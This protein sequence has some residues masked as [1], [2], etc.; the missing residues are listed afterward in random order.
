MRRRMMARLEEVPTWEELRRLMKETFVPRSYFLK[1]RGEL[2]DL[3]QWARSH[4][5]QVEALREITL[6]EVLEF[7]ETF[8]RQSKEVT[9]SKTRLASSQAG[10]GASTNKWSTPIKRVEGTSTMQGRTPYKASASPQTTLA[11]ITME[12]M[13]IG[14][15]GSVYSEDEEGKEKKE[16]DTSCNYEFSSEEEE[17]E[18]MKTLVVLRMLNVL[19]NLEEHREQQ[20]NIFHMKCKMGAKTCLVIIDGGS[21]ANEVSD[22]LVE[23]LGLKVVKHSHPYKLQWLGDAGELRVESQ[24]KMSLNLGEW[25]D[26]VLCDIISMTAYHA[27]LGRP[28]EYDRKVYKNGHIN[29]YFHMLNGMKLTLRPLTPKEV[30]EASQHLQRERERD[31]EKRLLSETR[32]SD[33]GW[34]LNSRSTLL[35][36]VRNDL[37][38]VSNTNTYPLLIESVLQGFQDV[39]PEKLPNGFPPIRS[40]EHQI[41]FVL[42]ST[43]PNRAAYKAN[44]K[45]MQELQR[46][47]EGLLAKG[48]VRESL[49]PCAVPVILVPKKDVIF[50]GFVV[51][52]DGVRVDEEKIQVIKDWPTPK[53]VSEV[54]SFHGLA[55]FYRRYKKGKE[56]VVADTLSRKPFES[57]HEDVIKVSEAMC[58]RKHV[59][60][61]CVSKFVGFEFIKDLY[62]H[63]YDFSSIYEACEKGV[64]DKYYRLDGYLYRENRLCIPSCSLRELMVKESHLGGLMSHFGALKTFEILN[65]HFFWPCM[66]KHVEKFCSQCIECRQAKSKSNNFGLYT[67][68]PT[69]RNPW[70]DISMDFVLGLPWSPKG[71]DIIFVVV[72]RFSKMAHFIP[73][74]KTSDAKF[75]ANLFFKEVVRNAKGKLTPRGDGPFL[76]LERI[77]GNAYVID[78]PAESDLRTNPSQERENDTNP[79]KWE[80]RP[81]TRSMARRAQENLSD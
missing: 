73:C 22:Q 8:E 57:M 66:R 45:K 19:P 49:S 33:L 31:K 48:L 67:P 11:T 71:N 65:K 27:L 50:L 12:I 64:F 30:Y 42:G 80:G 37:C 70:V 17:D 63:D 7:A 58:A 51:G 3:R 38:L 1:L 36:M 4:K 18:E 60:T 81:M 40:I 61:I 62:V 9:L 68:L 39:F 44:P 34:G 26:E 13:V 28:W 2:Q 74:R 16:A 21:C 77:N 23:K 56:N 32:P 52:R 29:E 46:Q 5:V 41:N 53:N 25:E 72:D 43:L 54:R 15:D 75:I 59:L 35:L 79:L 10:R 47:V 6:G 55:S 78:L 76:V 24:C 14:Q 69:P 20:C